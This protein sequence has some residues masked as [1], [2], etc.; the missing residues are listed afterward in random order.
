MQT[1]KFIPEAMKSQSNWVLWRKSYG[2]DRVNKY[3]CSP[4]DGKMDHIGGPDRWTTYRAAAKSLLEFN[5]S[6]EVFDGL[7]FELSGSGLIFIDL[8][9][10]LTNGMPNAMASDFLDTLSNTYCELS[11]S[12]SGLHFFLKGV[13]PHQH[14]IKQPE[15][16]LYFQ[17]R[18][19]ANTFDAVYPL[20]PMEV[21]SSVIDL[22][23]RWGYDF[24]KDFREQEERERLQATRSAAPFVAT[25]SRLSDSQVI[26]HLR[27]TRYGELYDHGLT[28]AYSSHSEADAALCL[29]LAFWTDKDPEQIDR[30]FRQSALFREKWDRE[31]YARRTIQKACG[32]C[33]QSYSGWVKKKTLDNLKYWGRNDKF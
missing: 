10:C 17:N 27:K 21:D 2:G 9:H 5:R 15:L 24:E 13:I 11:Q 3:P 22:L 7:G 14:C 6:G 4:L 19:C 20:E 26:Y 8:D 33:E 32:W 25:G 18:F 31:D 28:P 12:K 23:K 1:T 30:L 29:E 16:E